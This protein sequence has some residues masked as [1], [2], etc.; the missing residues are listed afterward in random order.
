VSEPLD[1]EPIR[2]AYDPAHDPSPT[3]ATV[4][5]LADEVEGLR[6]ELEITT[7]HSDDYDQV[8]VDLLDA[9]QENG[10]LDA[11]V[12]RH[13]AELAR[14]DQQITALRQTA[15]Q[16][17]YATVG[18]ELEAMIEQADGEVERKGGAS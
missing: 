8:L 4:N 7:R 18:P 1:L 11:E 14:R 16:R 6:A 12:E 3:A 5:R 9:Q 13:R 2:Y 10:E 15:K 17:Y